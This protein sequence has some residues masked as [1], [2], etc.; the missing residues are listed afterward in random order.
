M[1]EIQKGMTK[2]RR[3][4]FTEQQIMAALWQAESG[5]PMVEICRKLGITEQTFYRWKRK[6]ACMGVA[7]LRRLREVEEENRRLKQ[8][9]AYLTLDKQMLQE[10]CEK[11]LKPAQKRAVVQFFRVGYQVSERRACRVAGVLRSSCCYRGQARDQAPLRQ[12]LRE[13]AAVRVRYGYR[14]LHVLLD[15]EGWRVNHKRVDRLYREEGLVDPD[16]ALEEADEPATV[17][18]TTG[19]ATTGAVES[20]FPDRQLGR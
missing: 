9:V 5:T 7:E 17:V 2:M 8:L 12:R 4:R 16:Q 13:L 3:S 10:A 19:Q 20:R 6:F 1:N 18:P 14:R 11:L 15:R